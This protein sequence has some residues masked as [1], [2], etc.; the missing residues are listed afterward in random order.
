MSDDLLRATA[1]LCFCIAP[2]LRASD[3]SQPPQQP[4]SP[5]K[6]S[7]ILL[8]DTV[9]SDSLPAWLQ[10]GGQI[11][12]R[13]EDPSGTSITSSSWDAYYL[14]RIRLDL[15]IKPARWLRFF[16]EA[17]DARVAAYR[18]SPAPSSIYNPLDL[19]QGFVEV[20]LEG[21]ASITVRAGRQE[22]AF[23]GERLIG[24][25]DWGIS[26]TFDAVDVRISH[27]RARVDF[28]GGS[29]V[30]VDP[31]RLDRHKP[32][33]H[34]YG[35]YSSIENVLPG[36]NV[37]P[38]ALFK[39]TLRVKSELAVIGDALIASPGVRVF[40]RT[41]GRFDYIAEF[42]VQ[43]GSYSSDKVAAMATSLVTGWTVNRSPYKPRISVEY[44]YASGDRSNKDGT[45]NTFDQLYPSDHPY[46]GMIDQFGWQNMKN[47]RAGFD[48]SVTK[49]LK[50]RTDFN[51]FYV[52]T[53]QDALYSSSGSPAVL[54]RKA[55]SSHVGSEINN[56]ALYQWSKIWQFGAGYGHLFAG[57]YLKQSKAAFGYTYPYVVFVGNF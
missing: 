56:V 20:K 57:E 29:A 3:T 18:I 31:T 44:N 14:S 55:T 12:G 32:G 39:Q 46:Y 7:G 21:T 19:R 22:L 42:V 1:W 13:F 9:H 36:I 48:L 10:L 52:A 15:G 30:L 5:N 6:S 51:E 43:R 25:A 17:Q 16:A 40:G 23:G 47:V 37:E 33:E 27:G 34:I 45:R 4:A 24:P 38:Y 35:A 28:F 41:P 50:L 26:R 54:N 11:R 2:S 49:K 8:V 53:V